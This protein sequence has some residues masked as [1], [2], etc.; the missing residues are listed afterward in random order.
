[1]RSILALAVAV[2]V[3]PAPAAS[4]DLVQLDPFVQATGRHPACAAPAPPL[5]TREQ[6]ERSAHAR[7]ERGTRCAMEGSCEP[8][9][10]YRRDPEIN[11]AA[12]AAIAADG[13]FARTSVWVTTSRGWVTLQG[14]VGDAV[15]R[16]Q[17][18]E[19]VAKVPR[20]AKVFNETRSVPIKARIPRRPP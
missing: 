6:V 12:R 7:A 13:R 4:E 2:A 1:M 11:E 20:V 9:G 10:A 18:E 3:A 19:T 15:Q 14:C 17:L 5:M 8:G 16:L